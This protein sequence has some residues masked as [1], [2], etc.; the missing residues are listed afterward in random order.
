MLQQDKAIAVLGSYIKR[1]HN[2]P[3]TFSS[4]NLPPPIKLKKPA[5]EPPVGTVLIKAANLRAFLFE[6]SLKDPSSSYID[7][8]SCE[9]KLQQTKKR[10]GDYQELASQLSLVLGGG[11]VSKMVSVI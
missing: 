8:T 4:A 3:R 5:R 10:D 9:V 1:P 2:L 11:R 7:I 6:F